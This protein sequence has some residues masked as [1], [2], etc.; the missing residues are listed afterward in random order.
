M[1]RMGL[2]MDAL[3]LISSRKLDPCTMLLSL[4]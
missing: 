4:S 3:S 2:G 1:V